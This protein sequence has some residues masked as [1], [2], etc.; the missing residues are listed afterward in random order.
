[1]QIADVN[2]KKRGEKNV[3]ENYFHQYF[4]QCKFT[5]FEMSA[6]LD[7]VQ[8]VVKCHLS[9]IP[10]Y[11]PLNGPNIHLLNKFRIDIILYNAIRNECGMKFLKETVMANK[12][13]SYVYGH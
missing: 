3:G 13:D 6:S 4:V 2:K 12:R 9:F 8:P 7:A 11:W 1:M 5:Y 10:R